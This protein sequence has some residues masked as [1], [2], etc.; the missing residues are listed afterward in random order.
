M[1]YNKGIDAGVI[2]KDEKKTVE[3]I[4]YYFFGIVTILFVTGFIGA[5]FGFGVLMALQAVH[6]QSSERFIIE[7]CGMSAAMVS[8]LT[9]CLTLLVFKQK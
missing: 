6:R 7:A 1:V 4:M 9:I 3:K 2:V 5:Y 8:Y